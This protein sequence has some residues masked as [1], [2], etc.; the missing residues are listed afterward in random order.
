MCSWLKI[1]HGGFRDEDGQ[2][3]KSNMGDCRLDLERG[4]L[5][6]ITAVATSGRMITATG[7]SME[8]GGS[9]EPME[10]NDKRRMGIRSR[11]FVLC[12]VEMCEFDMLNL[13]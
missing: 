12:L 1:K 4:P 5:W 7:E 8:D 13:I 3:D 9:G 10:Y 11:G 2:C 6:R